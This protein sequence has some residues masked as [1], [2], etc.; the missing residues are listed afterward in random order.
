MFLVF[1][2]LF[3]N[4]QNWFYYIFGLVCNGWSG[5][6]NIVNRKTYIKIKKLKYEFYYLAIHNL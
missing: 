4:I 3:F 5:N 1:Q 6:I 2:F